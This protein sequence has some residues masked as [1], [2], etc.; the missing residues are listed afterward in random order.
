MQVLATDFDVPAAFV[1]A[2]NAVSIVAH[3]VDVVAY[4]RFFAGLEVDFDVPA[5]FMM[6]MHT[7]GVI[8]RRVDVDAFQG[9]FDGVAESGIPR[10]F[11]SFPGFGHLAAHGGLLR[12]CCRHDENQA[13]H[14]GE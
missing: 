13:E 10:A 2:V 12:R 7:V 3:R 8:V 4:Q 11:N 1:T 14:Q 5:A 6:A 9:E